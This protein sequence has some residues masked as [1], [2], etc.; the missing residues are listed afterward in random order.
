MC[1]IRCPSFFSFRWDYLSRFSRRSRRE[2]RGFDEFQRQGVRTRFLKS[3][4]PSEDF[5]SW[6]SIT[7]GMYPGDHGIIGNQFFDPSTPQ[8]GSRGESPNNRL[9]RPTAYFDH[10]D[11]RSTG[12][13]RWWERAKPIWATAMEQGINFTTLLWGR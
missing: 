3:V 4:F 12:E 8:A 5:P 13:V 11:E 1:I 7:T 2:F 6:R 10:N 9:S